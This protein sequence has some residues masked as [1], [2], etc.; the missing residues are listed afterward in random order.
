MLFFKKR[1]RRGGGQRQSERK[2]SQYMD[3]TKERAP[4]T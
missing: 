4:N 1:P 2:H 3:S